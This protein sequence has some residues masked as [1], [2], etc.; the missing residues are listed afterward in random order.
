MLGLL[1]QSQHRRIDQPVPPE[2]LAFPS[3]TVCSQKC[4]NA[5]EQSKHLPPQKNDH[6]ARFNFG[7][8][9]SDRFFFPGDLS[10]VSILWEHFP[11]Y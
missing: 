11:S 5:L 7:G 1:Y 10:K 4:F 3:H 6:H 8:H 2:D 9:S